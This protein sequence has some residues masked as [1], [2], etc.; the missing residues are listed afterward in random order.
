MAD[1]QIPTRTTTTLA[2][3]ARPTPSAETTPGPPIAPEAEPPSSPTN[4]VPSY[5]NHP[6]PPSPSS[7]NPVPSAPPPPPSS[8]GLPPGGTPS[9]EP[10]PVVP[11][12]P[13]LGAGAPVL[14]RPGS[15]PAPPAPP[16][17]AAVPPGPPSPPTPPRQ[18]RRAL[19]ALVVA[20]L[21][22]GAGTGGAAIALALDDDPAP[23]PVSSLAAPASTGGSSDEA[24]DE[25][26]SQVA[27]AVLPSVVS[28][29]FEAQGGVGQGSGVI[30]SED[31]QILTNNHV[32]EAAASGGDLE[33]TFS[34]GSRASAEIV[35]RD[36]ATD[37]AVI[38]AQDVSDLTPATLGSSGD[39]HVGDTVLAIGSPLGLT[40]S[41]TSG[42]VS[43]VD[44]AI[45]LGGSSDGSPF[46]EPGSGSQTTAV[47]DAIQTDAA[48]NPGNSGGALINS[49]GEVVGIN[50][51]I[52]STA[53]G[54][55]GSQS[56]NIGV[57]FA[58]PIDDAR[59]VADQLIDDG[60]VTHAYLG[61]QIADADTGGA[62]VG[63]VEPG[64]PAEDAGL[65]EGDV[66]TAVDGEQI[67]DSTGLT[68]AVRSHE[69]GDDVSLS[70]TRNGEDGTADVTLA[71]LPD[72]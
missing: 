62:L 43:A 45:T 13:P 10:S 41:V 32:V 46:G 47:I 1:E 44:R 7:E 70:Y 11:T 40:G 9:T 3:P 49:S 37:L 56:G 52:A 26:L 53:G 34:D 63:R 17:A 67:D 30:I 33:V 18:G 15:P 29:T 21:M 57:G 68:A 12:S 6:G 66:V 8:G 31:G 72:S 5:S 39:L 24:P 38:Q 14:G 2:D 36:P 65:R 4:P 69:P 42:I 16:S 35:G 19:T 64:S 54:V 59:D 50:T 61:V 58:V 22:L 60:T 23:T 28:I 48:I 71:E 51:A 55:T 27:D 20:A 25:G